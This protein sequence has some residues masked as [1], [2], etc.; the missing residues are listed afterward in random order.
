MKMVRGSI[1]SKDLMFAVFCFMQATVLRSGYIIGITRQD[2]WAMVITALLFTFPLVAIYAALLHKFPGKNLLEIDNIVFGPVLGK[3]VSA[4]Y[5]FFFASLAA[6]NM[7]DL[8]HFVVDYMMPGTPLAAVFCLSLVGCVYG[9][10][11]GIHSLMRLSTVICII[12]A[13]ALIFNFILVLRDIDPKFLRPLFQLEFG[14]YVQGTI[15]VA[16]VPMGEILAFTM[17]TPM[18]GEGIKAGKPLMLGL[19]LSALSMAIVVIRDIVT[20][21]PLV[22][23]VTLPSFE[24]VRY[25]SLAGFLTRME[26]FFAGILTILFLFKISVLLYAFA[27]GLT[28]ILSP[29][30]SLPADIDFGG[31]VQETGQPQPQKSH[32]PLL[33]L[34]AAFVFFYSLFI[35]ESVMENM[36]WGATAAPFFSLTFEFLLPAITLLTAG[37]KKFRKPHEVSA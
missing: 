29:K 35:F 1:S 5:L 13:A 8:G 24:S 27:M 2:S 12:S 25:I 15:S 21:G 18:L 9:I 7:R 10:Y 22:A 11:K 34:S 6:L 37:L 31:T 19:I 4:L 3:I 36:D 28:Q 23:N 30:N 14:K 16:A 17:L 33:L 26:S 20:L 32:P